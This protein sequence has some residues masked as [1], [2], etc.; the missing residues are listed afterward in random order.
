M[1]LR[2]LQVKALVVEERFPEA[3]NH[4]QQRLE[5]KSGLSAQAAA[6]NRAYSRRTNDPARRYSTSTDPSPA[7]SDTA[8]PATW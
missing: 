7:A 3:V 6:A 5:L 8:I 1:S 2:D 4:M